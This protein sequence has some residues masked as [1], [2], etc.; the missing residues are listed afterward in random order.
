[1]MPTMGNMTTTS[2][3]CDHCRYSTRDRYC[4]ILDVAIAEYPPCHYWY[5]KSPR[6]R[7][8]ELKLTTIEDLANAQPKEDLSFAELPI[9]KEGAGF[10]ICFHLGAYAIASL[11]HP[12]VT[13]LLLL[14][15]NG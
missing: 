6:S 15:K 12:D 10:N 13:L 2:S 3:P 4:K 11:K 8:I 1:M 9:A 5:Y 7:G 14:S